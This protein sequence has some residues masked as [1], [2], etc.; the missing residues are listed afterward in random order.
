MWS[1]FSDWSTSCQFVSRDT[2]CTD[3]CDGACTSEVGMYAMRFGERGAVM[4]CDVGGR[5]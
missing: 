5:S 2:S 1:G 4:L 3:D